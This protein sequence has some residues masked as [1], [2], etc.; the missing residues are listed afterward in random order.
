MRNL[1]AL[2]GLR[3]GNTIFR[4]EYNKRR[5]STGFFVEIYNIKLKLTILK[6]INAQGFLD[7]LIYLRSVQFH[8]NTTKGIKVTEL[9]PKTKCTGEQEVS[10]QS[11]DY[12]DFPGL[13]IFINNVDAKFDQIVRQ[14]KA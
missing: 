9:F 12:L 7:Q 13:D 14:T 4:C 1:S 11:R 10:S 8:S 3:K 2:Y 5:Y 6:F